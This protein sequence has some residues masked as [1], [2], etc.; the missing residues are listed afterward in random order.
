MELTA[1]KG[2]LLK[3]QPLAGQPQLLLGGSHALSQSWL[4]LRPLPE[5]QECSPLMLATAS[6][7]SEYK[8]A[9]ETRSLTSSLYDFLIADDSAPKDTSH[10]IPF[11]KKLAKILPQYNI[12]AQRS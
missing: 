3:A 4:Q 6:W 9:L 11:M 8:Y 12:S 2:S 7:I 1:A 10:L 5:L